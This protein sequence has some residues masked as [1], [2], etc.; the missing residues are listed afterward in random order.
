MGNNMKLFDIKLFLSF[1]LLVSFVL[2]IS[3]PTS[4]WFQLRVPD[5]TSAEFGQILGFAILHLIVLI[6]IWSIPD[7]KG[8][9]KQITD[10]KRP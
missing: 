7:N 1:L 4:Q 10:D 9:P 5:F 8:K 6:V 3:Y 2:L